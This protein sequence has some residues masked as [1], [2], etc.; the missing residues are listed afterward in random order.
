MTLSDYEKALLAIV[1]FREARSDGVDGM[2]AV[3]SV[4][5]NRVKA[6]WGSWASVIT[7]RNQ[8]SSISVIGDSQTVVYPGDDVMLFNLAESIYFGD[9]PDPTKG[10]LYYA[11]EANVT[12]QWYKD[13]IMTDAHPVLA[14]IGSQTFR[15]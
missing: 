8:F 5:A 2:A 11:N 14:V 10:S 13:N 15:Q 12:S 6:G 3:G 4:V 7:K 1:I 9:I